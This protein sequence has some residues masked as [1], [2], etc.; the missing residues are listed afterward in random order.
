MITTTSM[1]PTTGLTLD[2]DVNDG[3][4]AVPGSFVEDGNDDLFYVCA[5]CAG[6]DDV[7]D[8]END[9]HD[10]DDGGNAVP[11]AND[12]AVAVDDV[13]SGVEDGCNNLFYVCDRCAGG[14]E[15]MTVTT[16][17]MTS[18]TAATPS[19]VPT[20]SL[21]PPTTLAE[22]MASPSALSTST[23]VAPG[24]VLADIKRD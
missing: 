20:T 18:T 5:R 23:L 10:I 8:S 13:G 15:A 19:Q 1:A 12:I 16:T 24:T 9:V 11:G 21:L 6:D 4:D 2:N 17:S 22:G 7:K 14:D 3:D